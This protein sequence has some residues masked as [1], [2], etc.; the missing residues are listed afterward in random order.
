M[1]AKW[2]WDHRET[3]QH[4][5][6]LHFLSYLALARLGIDCLHIHCHSNLTKSGLEGWAIGQSLKLLVYCQ[7]SCPID[8]IL[9]FLDYTLFLKFIVDYP[10]RVENWDL[11][12]SRRVATCQECHTY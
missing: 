6:L 8:K 4:R 9:F 5:L 12:F 11:S 10:Q 1:W 2:R 7:T 3:I